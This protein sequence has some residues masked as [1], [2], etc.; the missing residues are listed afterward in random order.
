MVPIGQQIDRNGNGITFNYG[1]AGSSGFP[2]LS[3]IVDKNNVALLTFNRTGSFNLSSMADRYGRSVYYHGAQYNNPG[4]SLWELDH[5][6]QIVTTGAA[7]PPDRYVYGYQ[8]VNNAQSALQRYY[9]RKISGNRTILNSLREGKGYSNAPAA[10]GRVSNVTSPCKSVRVR[11]STSSKPVFA[12]CTASKSG[13]KP[14]PVSQTSSVAPRTGHFE[15][16]RDLLPAVLQRVGIQ[17]LRNQRQRGTLP[18]AQDCIVQLVDQFVLPGHL[19]QFGQQG[20]QHPARGHALLA[21]FAP[22]GCRQ[23]VVNNGQ[24]LYLRA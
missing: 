10:C 16:D 7:S 20:G 19:A 5:V 1:A 24:A 14:G 18:G 12:A 11:F 3:S 21:F 2:L 6:S 4:S 8:S 23:H 22:R 15:S 17:F 13:G 9:K